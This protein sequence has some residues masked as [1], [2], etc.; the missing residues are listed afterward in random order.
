MVEIA[1][2][3]GYTYDPNSKPP[4]FGH[5]L[6]KYWAFDKDYINLNHGSYGSQPLP[7]FTESSKLLLQAE[8]NPDKFHRRGYMPLL[9]ESRQLIADLV[10]ADLDEIVFVPNATH[11][12]NTVLRSIE[13][14]EG[15]IL[16]GTS[17][18]YG[19]ITKTLQFLADRSEPPRPSVYSVT[20]TF[21]MSHQQIVDAFRARI[22]ELKQLHSQ[23]QF[24]NVPGTPED[25][26]NRFVAVIDSIASN[27][28]VLLPWQE[29]VKVCEE[30]NV[31]SVIDAAHSIGQELSINLT[32]AKPD[33]WISN[34]HKWLFAK[35]SCAILY[36]PERNQHI[37]K[38]SMPTSHMY[39]Q[40]TTFSPSG[41][42][43]PT[44][45]AQHEWTGTQD[46]VPFL[47]VKAAIAFRNW[48]GGEE[49]INAYC[50]DLAVK[51][52]LRLA[53]ALN[54]KIIDESGELTLNMTNVLLPLPVDLPGNT[55]VYT[56]ENLA[57]MNIMLRDKLLDDWNVYAAHYYH[58]GA[59]WVRAS[60]QVWNEI[61]DFEE[62][63]KAL[64]HVCKE[65]SE[66]FFPGWER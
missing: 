6:K 46:Q 38:S 41:R 59:W 21:P 56:E 50:H 15:D 43:I 58:A 34:C 31:W 14:R 37:I 47:S 5:P 25:K 18:T 20:Y 19:A 10:G 40:K 65:V 16:I 27:P 33:F 62:L 17:T 30:E 4:P 57:A 42:P 66:H 45:V 1:P 2:G 51:G 24:T 7:V 64:I 54:T 3:T 12:L 63:G 9:V 22:R 39:G 49:K 44:F 23:S 36:V 55:P 48:L 26:S 8:Q 60:A 35:R 11:G 28:G 13:W 29:L 32:E 52:G 61:S 53:E